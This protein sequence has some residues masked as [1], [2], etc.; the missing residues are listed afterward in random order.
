MAT[1][2]QTAVGETVCRY[3]GGIETKGREWLHTY[4]QW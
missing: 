1:H 3:G 4:I 2:L